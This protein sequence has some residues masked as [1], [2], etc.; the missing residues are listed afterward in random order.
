MLCCLQRILFTAEINSC[1]LNSLSFTQ[2]CADCP[3]TVPHQQ[4]RKASK[5][6]LGGRKQTYMKN[7]NGHQNWNYQT[8]QCP[9]LLKCTNNPKLHFHCSR[10]NTTMISS[11]FRMRSFGLSSLQLAELIMVST[12]TMTKLSQKSPAQTVC[13][14]LAAFHE[15]IPT[16]M[17]PQESEQGRS[18]SAGTAV[19]HCSGGGCGQVMAPRTDPR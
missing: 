6:H 14:F 7:P 1:S 9:E 10:T 17:D 19:P 2:V 3:A 16:M 13:A 4:L 5:T 12:D 15:Y 8:I 11:S 18:Y